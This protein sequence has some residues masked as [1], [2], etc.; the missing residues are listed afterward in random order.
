[1]LKRR[2]FIL[3]VCVSKKIYSSKKDTVTSIEGYRPVMET[4]YKHINTEI[5]SYKHSAK[6]M[7]ITKGFFFSA[8]NMG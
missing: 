5:Q 6:N 7:S 8:T 2:V 4:L 3:I 1:V